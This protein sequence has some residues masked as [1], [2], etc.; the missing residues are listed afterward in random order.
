MK[1][2]TGI[3]ITIIFLVGS[4]CFP[5]DVRSENKT[6]LA[7]QWLANHKDKNKKEGQ[8][9]EELLKMKEEELQKREESLNKKEEQ[10]KAWENRLKKRSQ[11]RRGTQTTPSPAAA[12][13]Q[14]TIPSGPGTTNMPASPEPPQTGK[15]K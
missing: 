7:G 3:I 11:V 12:S 14:A 2:L 13:P 15:P 1:Q 10:L 8:E 5:S 4:V 6:P 9:K